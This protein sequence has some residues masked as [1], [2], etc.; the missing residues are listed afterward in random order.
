MVQSKLEDTTGLLVAIAMF[1]GIY[2]RVGDKVGVDHTY[3]SRVINGQRRSPEVI[4]AMRYELNIIRDYLN[5]TAGRSNG[6]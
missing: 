4:A 6:V 1:R 2:G 5:R 3:V